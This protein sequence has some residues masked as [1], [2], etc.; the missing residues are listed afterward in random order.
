MSA[1]GS[2]TF[3]AS[4]DRALPPRPGTARARLSVGDELEIRIALLG[5]CRVRVV[6]VDDLEPDPADPRGPPRGRADHLRGG[7]RRPRGGLV[8]RILSRTRASGLI[9][10]LGYL[11][12]GKQMQARCWIRFIGRVAEACG[13][14]VDGPDPCADPEGRGGAGRLR[15]AA[16]ARPPSPATRGT[17]MALWRFGRG[18]TEAELGATSPH[19]Q[20]RPS[21]S[22]TP[23]RR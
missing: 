6:H 23:P 12:M 22:T 20:D 10:Y 8:F 13:G 15:R 1:S 19:S 14:R 21:T 9:N 3:A 5:Q 2:S 11:L 17:T 18:W 7:A 16:D 4:R